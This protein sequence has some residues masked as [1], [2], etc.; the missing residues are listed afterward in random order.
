MYK[1][2]TVSLL[3]VWWFWNEGRR[4]FLP[5]VSWPIDAF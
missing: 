5:V 4:F 2:D 3:S 1:E